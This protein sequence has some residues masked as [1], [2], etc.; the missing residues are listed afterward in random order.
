MRTK[1]VNI[2][3]TEYKLRSLTRGEVRKIAA[4]Q[5]TEEQADELVKMTLGKDDVDDI[6]MVEFSKIVDEA[7]AYNCLGGSA[8]A[9]AKKN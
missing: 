4:L 1:T 2:E 7:V 9:D 8:V 5:S 6:D 3:G